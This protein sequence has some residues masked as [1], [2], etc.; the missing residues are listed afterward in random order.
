MYREFKPVIAGSGM[1]SSYLISSHV[2][3]GHQKAV[4]CVECTD[5]VLFSSSAGKN[6]T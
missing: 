5:D 2:V 6:T 3:D 1:Q 4:L